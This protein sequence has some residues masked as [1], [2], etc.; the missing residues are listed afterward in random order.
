[1][2]I[3]QKNLFEAWDLFEKRL[4][5]KYGNI[6]LFVPG[7]GLPRS[8]FNRDT[9]EDLIRGTNGVVWSWIIRKG[10][11]NDS[12]EEKMY[13]IYYTLGERSIG[14]LGFDGRL[15]V[16]INQVTRYLNQHPGTTAIFTIVEEAEEE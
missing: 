4:K 8:V 13:Y 12:K 9:G 3:S 14:T 15:Q 7:A 5:E 6:S 2:R 1:M 10:K 16:A 11:E